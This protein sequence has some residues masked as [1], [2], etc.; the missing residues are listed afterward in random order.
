MGCENPNPYDAWK[1]FK[2]PLLYRVFMIFL[3]DDEIEKIEKKIELINEVRR[4]DVESEINTRRKDLEKSF[5][6]R[7]KR[8]G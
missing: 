4:K 7:V 3:S 6:R 2:L 5:F 8:Y 1:R